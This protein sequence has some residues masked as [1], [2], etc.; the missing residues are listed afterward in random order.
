ECEVEHK[1]ERQG[2]ATTVQSCEDREDKEGEFSYDG[3][4]W[5]LSNQDDALS[6]SLDTEGSM[7]CNRATQAKPK[8][9]SRQELEEEGEEEE[10]MEEVETEVENMECLEDPGLEDTENLIDEKEDDPDWHCQ[11]EDKG[12]DDIDADDEETESTPMN[13][14]RQDVMILIGHYVLIL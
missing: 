5:D 7:A 11:M 14:I 4:L 1:V 9:R 3:N 2:A 10:D 8:M 12:D 6:F 13:N